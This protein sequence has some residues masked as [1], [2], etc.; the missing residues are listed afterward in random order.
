[1]LLARRII[2]ENWNV[3]QIENWIRREKNTGKKKA[4]PDRKHIDPNIRAAEQK[5]QEVLGTRV[6]IH[7]SSGESGRLE[8]YF[9]NEEDLIRIYDR[10]AEGK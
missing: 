3:R 6:M 7:R 5:L 10:I 9:Q 2:E 4:P 8:I 1:M